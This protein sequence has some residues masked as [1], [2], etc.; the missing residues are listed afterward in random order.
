MFSEYEK[1]VIDGLAAS[2]ASCRQ[3]AAKIGRSYAAIASYV[4]NPAGYGKKKHPGRPRKLT[5]RDRRAVVKVASNQMISCAKIKAELGLS[6]NKTTIWREL[7]RSAHLKWSR[8]NAAPKLKDHHKTARLDFARKYMAIDWT[9][10]SE[11]CEIFT[12]KFL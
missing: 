1:G 7:N 9:K 6:V 4:R 5:P 12:Y 10:V 11:L 2:N 8:M 3:I